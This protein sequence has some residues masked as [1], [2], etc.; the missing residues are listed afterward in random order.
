GVTRASVWKCIDALRRQGYTVEATTNRGYRVTAVPDLLT[1]EQVLAAVTE[2]AWQQII[3]IEETDSTNLY[4]NRLILE[5]AGDG[6]VVIADRQTK[7]M[8][9]MGRSFLSLPGVGIYLS[10]ILEPHCTAKELGLLT[11]YA[12]LAVCR[13]T[14]RVCGITPQIKWPNDIIIEGKKVCGILTRLV[15]DAETA[16][17]TH[18]IVG[19][20]INVR[21]QSFPEELSQKAISLRQATGRDFLRAELA[22]EIINELNR[23]LRVEKWL[24]NPPENALAQL[25]ALSCT[26]GKRVTVIGPNGSREGVAMNIDKSGGLLVYFDDVAEVVASGEVSV[27][28][29]L[30][31]TP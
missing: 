6:T 13:A 30:G 23:M 27:R 17:I 25:R 1:R 31:Y 4:A 3:C 7:G 28:G 8:G 24:E 12:G 26:V 20:G 10:M 5:G 14:E 2:S 29:I 11:S 21:Q 19:I 15:S 9:R 16:T 18:A 22:G